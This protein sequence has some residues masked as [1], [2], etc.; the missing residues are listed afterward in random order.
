MRVNVDDR[1]GAAANRDAA[2]RRGRLRS[3]N[4]ATA[5]RPPSN[6]PAVAPATFLR[7]VLRLGIVLL[8]TTP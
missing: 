6:M 1:D 2:P 5:R 8:L 3:V 4:A 7:K